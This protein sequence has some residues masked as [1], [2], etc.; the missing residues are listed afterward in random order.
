[1]QKLIELWYRLTHWII[2]DDFDVTPL[3]GYAGHGYLIA[4]TNGNLD[5]RKSWR[6]SV[7]D[8]DA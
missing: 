2:P 1:M 4:L 6:F 3:E 5:D 7:L 8:L